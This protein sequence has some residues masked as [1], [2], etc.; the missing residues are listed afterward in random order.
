MR[1][2]RATQGLCVAALGLTSCLVPAATALATTSGSTH[3]TA[4]HHKAP[5]NAAVPHSVVCKDV[6]SEETSQSH[7]G[8]ALATALESGHVDRAKH[9]MLRVL[10]AELKKDATASHALKRAPSKVRAAEKHLTRDVQHVR[11]EV[12]RS[13]S[14]KQLLAAFA[15]LSRNTH[16]AADGVTLYYWFGSQCAKP[17][18]PAAPPASSPGTTGTPGTSG[19]SGTSGTSGAPGGSP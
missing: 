16:L 15:T 3:P 11:G 2:R 13:S 12:A 14:I 10:D 8:L 9:G 1:Q 18:P 5:K 7:L 19:G 4:T 6:Q 17:R